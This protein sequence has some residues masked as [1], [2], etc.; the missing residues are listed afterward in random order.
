MSF[1]INVVKYLT[2]DVLPV[3]QQPSWLEARGICISLLAC[4]IRYECVEK[5]LRGALSS[6]HCGFRLTMAENPAGCEYI[7]NRQMLHC[8]LECCEKTDEQLGQ[9][10]CGA[11]IVTV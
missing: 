6:S 7:V 9:R 1:L 4:S 8:R 11:D 2:K 5:T 3:R 10:K